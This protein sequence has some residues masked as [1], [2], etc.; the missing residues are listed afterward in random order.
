MTANRRIFLN[1]AATY[2]R[3]L[4]SLV[5]GL[6]TSRWLLQALGKEGLGLFSVVGGLTM[7]V[8]MLNDIMAGSVSRY[9]AVAVGEAK[10]EGNAVDGLENCRQ[11]FNCALSIHTILPVVLVMI[12]YP[13]GEW[14]VRHFLNIPPDKV[15]ACVWVWRFTCITCFAAMV[16]V[17]F[18]AMYGAKQEIAELTIYSVC[19]TAA[20]FCFIY[21]MSTHPQ[22]WLAKYAAWA[23]LVSVTPQ[24]LICVRA[25]MVYPECRFN[26]LYL[27]NRSRFIELAKFAF[28]KLWGALSGLA[29]GQGDAIVVNKYFGAACNAAKGYSY[30]VTSHI[31]TLAGSL[32]GAFAPAIMNLAGAGEW[33]KVREFSLRTCKIGGVLMLLFMLP[34]AIEL[35]NLLVL[36]LRNPPEWTYELTLCAMFGALCEQLTEGYSQAIFAKGKIGGYQ[37]WIGNACF[38]SFGLG[39]FLAASG[40]GVLS[41]GY[42]YIFLKI[43]VIIVRLYY[44]KKVVGISP[45]AC[46]REVLLPTVAILGLSTA[47]GVIPR[48]CL[49]ECFA[50][51]IITTIVTEVVFLPLA[52]F[53]VLRRDERAFVTDRILKKFKRGQYG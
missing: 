38:A 19:Q 25:C 26:R 14:A 42:S 43:C 12:G 48:L 18:R 33:D 5:C 29:T 40:I 50:R 53:M 41:V 37:F 32:N 3:S 6:C 49:S 22:E 36:W 45:W 17:P 31:S 21:Y 35:D 15:L 23:C 34:A 28:Y 7:F 11:W 10:R 47:V 52:W 16:N 9:Y 2:G 4:F 13:C 30:M 39:W 27:F 1:I 51:V 8:T 24:I 46:T 20:N 44:G